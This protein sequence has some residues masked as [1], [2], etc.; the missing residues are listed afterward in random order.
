MPA[1]P[2]RACA[3]YAHCFTCSK[4][5]K[6]ASFLT[7][8]LAEHGVA[9]LGSRGFGRAPASLPEAPEGSDLRRPGGVQRVARVGRLRVARLGV[10]PARHPLTRLLE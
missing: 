6:A 7:S 10:E 4:E 9:A 3:L 2:P 5:S 1:L 8:G